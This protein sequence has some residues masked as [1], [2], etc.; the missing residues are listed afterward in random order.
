VSVEPDAAAESA[1]PSDPAPDRRSEPAWRAFLGSFGVAGIMGV[2]LGLAWWLLAPKIRVEVTSTSVVFAP[3]NPSDWFGREGWFAILGLLLG[4]VAGFVAHRWWWRRS[5]PALLGVTVGGLLAS[6]LG[7]QLGRWLG[8]DEMPTGA[9][10]LP[11]GTI[12]GTPL[13]LIAPMVLLAVPFAAVLTFGLAVAL[14][15]DDREGSE[16]QPRDDGTGESDPALAR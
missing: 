5:V 16:A 8:P 10:D 7:Y 11:A 9:A 3:G 12:L 13:E 14:E 15:R 4:A 2:P 1:A 6:W